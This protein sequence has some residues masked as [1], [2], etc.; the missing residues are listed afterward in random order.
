MKA[1]DGHNDVLSRL[2]QAGAGSEVKGSGVLAWEQGV[3][4]SVAS[5]PSPSGIGA[6]LAK[7]PKMQLRA[8]R[9]DCRRGEG[10]R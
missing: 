10:L 8:P 9:Q 7:T 2:R 6:C 1:F 5:S 3:G 4:N